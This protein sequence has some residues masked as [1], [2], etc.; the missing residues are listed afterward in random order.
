MVSK[1]MGI[2][3]RLA[4]VLGGFLIASA[5]VLVFASAAHDRWGLAI[6]NMGLLLVCAFCLRIFVR[7]KDQ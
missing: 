3:I 2:T 5:A 4:R 7:M 1:G 6:A